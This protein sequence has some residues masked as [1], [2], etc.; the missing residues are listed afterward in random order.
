[1]AVSYVSWNSTRQE[2]TRC[3][4]LGLLVLICLIVPVTLADAK[5]AVEALWE[6]ALSA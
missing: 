4:A 6:A 5:K 1:M 3:A 2:R